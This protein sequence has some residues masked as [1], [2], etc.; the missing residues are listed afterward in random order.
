MHGSDDA[1]AKVEPETEA[2]GSG[3]PGDGGDAAARAGSTEAAVAFLPC[4]EEAAPSNVRQRGSIILLVAFVTKAK[5]LDL[6]G[7]RRVGRRRAAP[8]GPSFSAHHEQPE[9]AASSPRR[10]RVRPVALVRRDEADAQKEA[11]SV[12]QSRARSGLLGPTPGGCLLAPDAADHLQ[13]TGASART[14]SSAGHMNGSQ[15]IET[16]RSV[17]ADRRGIEVTP[18]E[19]QRHRGTRSGRRTA[20]RHRDGE[21][22]VSRSHSNHS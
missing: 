14:W 3:R 5:A 11:T 7:I 8:P 12:Q 4:I 9:H 2:A 18:F 6:I 16:V 19:D 13:A 22:Y 20:T 17:A 15:P 1:A 21:D 10:P